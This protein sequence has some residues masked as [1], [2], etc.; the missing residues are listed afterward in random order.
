M[1]LIRGKYYGWVRR[2]VLKFA[3]QLG[4]HP[5]REFFGLTFDTL[6]RYGAGQLSD[7]DL[8]SLLKAGSRWDAEKH[9]YPEYFAHP[10]G[11]VDRPYFVESQAVVSVSENSFSGIGASR[12]VVRGT[13]LVLGSP[14]EAFEVED[15]SRSILVTQ[16]TDPAWIFILSK[17]AGLV[18]EKGSLLS[19]TAIIGRELGI[20]TVVGVPGVVRGLKTGDATEIDGEKGL[21]RKI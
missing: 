17:C 6:N 19:H 4:G 13:A 21:V 16:T 12:G 11:T 9:N 8:E 18:S 15:L 2:A 5:V 10:E 1:R 7:E 20:P 3:E 14:Q